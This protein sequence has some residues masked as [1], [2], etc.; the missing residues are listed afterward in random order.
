AQDSGTY[1]CV[2]GDQQ[3]SASLQVKV[4]P[5]LFKKELKNVETE[6]GGTAV[7]HCEISKPNAPVEWRKGNM[8]LEPSDKYEMKLKGRVAELIIHGVEPDDC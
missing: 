3:A 2:S 8:V 7:L 5:V 4:L 6:E 1:T